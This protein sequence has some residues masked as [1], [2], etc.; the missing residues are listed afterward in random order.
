[1]VQSYE[2][3]VGEGRIVEICVR[4]HIVQRRLPLFLHRDYDEPK[5]GQAV[6]VDDDDKDELKKFQGIL[7]ILSHIHSL[8]D[9]PQ[10]RNSHKL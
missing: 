6:N 7:R 8:N 2:I 1:M 5:A 9:A 10:T 3:L 4:V